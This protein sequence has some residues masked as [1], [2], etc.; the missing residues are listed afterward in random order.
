MVKYTLDLALKKRGY[1]INNLYLSKGSHHRDL[2]DITDL[3]NSLSIKHEWNENELQVNNELI[4]GM[5]KNILCFPAN[6][7]ETNTPIYLASWRNF[8]RRKHGP[9]I[10]TKT[11]EPGVALMVKA[12]SAIGITT[13]NSCDGHG[14]N[15][16]IIDF[17][18][19]HNAAW[20]EILQDK[21]LSNGSLIY[22]WKVESSQNSYAYLTAV[23]DK[24]S[25]Q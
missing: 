19:F 21:Y 18:S 15:K 20:F 25:V 8:T 1:L 12:L 13:V 22:K 4:E 2:V 17:A 16:P 5:Y 11:L 23:S 7:R 3:L 14:K 10:Q 9:K 6:N 24:Y